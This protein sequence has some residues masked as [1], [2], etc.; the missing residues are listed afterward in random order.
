LINVDA[1]NGSDGSDSNGSV[2][3]GVGNEVVVAEKGK[4]QACGRSAGL[5]TC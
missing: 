1:T 4:V 3:G 2:A 5:I